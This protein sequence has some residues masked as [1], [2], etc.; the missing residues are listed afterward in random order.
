[1][2]ARLEIPTDQQVS[3][4]RVRMPGQHLPTPT[5]GLH[6]QRSRY[7][8]NHP[9]YLH[10][11]KQ[12]DSNSGRST[13]EQTAIR[14][15]TKKIIPTNTMKLRPHRTALATDTAGKSAAHTT[16]KNWTLPLCSHGTCRHC[17]HTVQRSGPS[18]LRKKLQ[19]LQR[20]AMKSQPWTNSPAY[21]HHS[22]C[23]CRGTTTASGC[24]VDAFSM[25]PVTSS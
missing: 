16:S 11:S 14:P 5:G 23:A 1:M 25:C 3:N 9:Q 10:T 2:Q 13:A 18:I 24:R 8:H 12:Q 7:K 20:H 22:L 21:I 19:S 6:G 15:T 17:A 4:T